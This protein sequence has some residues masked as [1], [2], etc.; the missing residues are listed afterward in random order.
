M[1][2]ETVKPWK[3]GKLKGLVHLQLKFVFKVI[4]AYLEE[5]TEWQQDFKVYLT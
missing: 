4:L 1:S 5:V 3:Q 2:Q